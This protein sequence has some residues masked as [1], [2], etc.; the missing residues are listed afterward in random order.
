MQLVGV[1][2]GTRRDTHLAGAAAAAQEQHQ[3]VEYKHNGAIHLQAE[4]EVSKALGRADPGEGSAART[5]SEHVDNRQQHNKAEHRDI[6]LS[7]AIH[8]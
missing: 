3:D 4:S 2:P 8:I 7:T 5:P 6:Q 1:R